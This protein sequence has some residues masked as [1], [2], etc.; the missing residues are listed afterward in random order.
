MNTT[1]KTKKKNRTNTALAFSKQKTVQPLLKASENKSKAI[2][3]AAIAVIITL[4]VYIPSLGNDFIVNWDDG[5]YIQ[6]HVLVHTLSWQNFITI[7]NPTTFYKGN[8]HPITTFS[9]A[10]EYAMVG[11]HALLYHINNLIFHLLDVLLVFWFIRLIT[12]RIEI[13]GF[14][15]LLFGIHPM[16]VESVAW[17][18][19]RKDVLYTFFFMLS[20][21]QYFFYFTKKEAKQKHYILALVFFFLSLLSKS[22]AVALPVAMF[23][24][25]YFMKRKLNAKLFIEKIPFFAL[26]I[27]IGIIAVFSQN[28]RGAIHDLT[29][30]FSIMD[31][32]VI[33]S[34][35]TIT[36]FW[37][38]FVPI[39]LSTMYPY[40]PKINGMFPIFYYIA[41]FL[42]L[43]LIAI[44]VFTR[45]FGR[46]FIFG[47]L[48]FFFNIALVI[49]IIPVGGAVLAERYT[50]VPYIGLFFIFGT[51]FSKGINSTAK[52]I[53]PIKPLFYIL[54]AG[55]VLF[56]SVLTW[57]RI[58]KWKNG[59][60]LM[61]DVLKVY[62]NSTFAYN[63]LGYYY[64]HWFK[65]YDKALVQ[66]NAS[67]Q[68]D[69]TNYETWSNRGVV[70][71]NMGQY[72][73]AIY[74]FTKSIKY[75]P[76]NT[77]GF[78]GR[79][80]SLSTLNRFAEAL[81]DY[82]K[83]LEMKPDDAKAYL[84]RGTAL[85]NTGKLDAAMV[86][87]DKCEKMT[88]NDYEV[89][90]WKGLVYF[91]RDD[92]KTALQFLDKSVALKP[93]K[94]DVYSWRGLTRYKLKMLDESIADY[95]TAISM[96]PKDA[97]AFVNR[98]IVYYD[99]GLYQQAW[100]DI[101]TAG[102]MGFPLD[103]PFFLK[104]QAKITGK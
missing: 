29:P 66:Y 65:Y 100:A 91:K 47:V 78:I 28:E 87:F 104:L 35:S 85:I 41:P 80:N 19:E 94:G 38:L 97:A 48:F 32:V 2:W 86:D 8:Y 13:A 98:A 21:I 39:N 42:V 30:L 34:N 96:N 71:N 25:D 40:P 12:K 70:Y 4:I 81:P 14:V 77:D 83:Y 92:F 90:F 63:N 10:L 9:Y 44:L 64:Y 55:F 49:Q 61:K 52:S 79:A 50:Y 17:I 51:L 5:G 7:F 101:N 18:S 15:A 23:V 37:K 95:C 59:E 53:R 31:R 1:K 69:T 43:L 56:F 60:V 75:K 103:K 24:V 88:P 33:V 26:S 45:K 102:K 57:Q 84:W 89:Y 62:P 16:H 99:K 73:K 22:A 68:F 72:E 6:E 74:D 46:H 3:Y 36:Y 76:D 82:D 11:E 27:A 54:F 58:G 20:L 93:V 67:M